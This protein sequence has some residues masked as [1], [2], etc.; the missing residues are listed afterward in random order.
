VSLAKIAKPV[1][2]P[3]M[4]AYERS[5]DQFHH[6]ESNTRKCGTSS[7]C[8]EGEEAREMNVTKERKER[9]KMKI[10]S[11]KENST[12]SETYPDD[13]SIVVHG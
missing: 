7:E 3:Q 8:Q 2:P 5:I 6:H 13:V 1:I 11:Q 10:C 4:I 12:M 9:T